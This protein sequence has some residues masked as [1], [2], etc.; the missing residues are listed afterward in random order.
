MDATKNPNLDA[1]LLLRLIDCT[2]RQGQLT[3]ELRFLRIATL[4][5][6]RRFNELQNQV[7]SIK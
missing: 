4:A 3:N 5:K 6:T 1:H 2:E 7:D